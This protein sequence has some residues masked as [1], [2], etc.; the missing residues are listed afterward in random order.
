MAYY[1]MEPFDRGSVSLGEAQIAALLANVY[2]K[3]GAPT[4]KTTDFLPGQEEPQ[5]QTTEGTIALFDKLVK[6]QDPKLAKEK[7]GH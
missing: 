7:R 3:K 4:F 5:V 6:G 2:R 1:R